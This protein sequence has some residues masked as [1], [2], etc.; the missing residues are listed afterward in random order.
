M[1]RRLLPLVASNVSSI[2]LFLL[3]GTATAQLPQRAMVDML[4]IAS[5]P[6]GGGGGPTNLTR[7]LY[8]WWKLDDSAGSAALDSSGSGLN[9][10][11][12]NSPAWVS[13]K[14]GGALECRAT[15]GVT[16]F[17]S[18]AT[19]FWQYPTGTI[20][21][22]MRQTNT[23]NCNL[24]RSIFSF[25]NVPGVAGLMGEIYSDNRWYLGWYGASQSP[26][27]RRWRYSGSYAM[28]PQNTWAHYA[29][30]WNVAA[31]SAV[32]LNGNHILDNGDDAPI[33]GDA[34]KN[35]G[36]PFRVGSGQWGSSVPAFGGSIDDFRI[37]TNALSADDI[38]YLYHTWY[39]Q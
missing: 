39:G 35:A 3:V 38:S 28:S 26:T 9:G 27:D 29:F 8:A 18:Y 16:G 14:V 19:A 30:V 21:W 2:I 7:A 12:T 25:W 15:G 23:W 5:R 32:Y 13:G 33:S 10:I 4:T 22:W 37:Y 31:V 34:V 11:L 36:V 20:T 17:Y 1:M 6:T 24:E